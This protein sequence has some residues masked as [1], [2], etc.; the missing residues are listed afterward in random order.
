M[1]IVDEAGKPM[2]ELEKIVDRLYNGELTIEEF[3]VERDRW[4]D[5][6]SKEF[7]DDK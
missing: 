3:I 7:E 4:F 6:V 5:K 1:N 2:F